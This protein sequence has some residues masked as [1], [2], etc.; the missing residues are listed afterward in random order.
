MGENTLRLEGQVVIV[1]G[2]ASGIGEAAARGFAAEG[3]KV[4]ITDVDETLGSSV[5]ASIPS[6]HFLRADVSQ[7]ADVAAAVD[8]ALSTYGRLDI[9]HNNAAIAGPLGPVT[10]LDMDAFDRVYSINLRGQVL[11]IKHAARAMIPAHRGTIICTS[12][13]ATILG[14]SAPNAYTFVK[15]AIPGIVRSA[16]AELGPHGIR[17]NAISPLGVPTPGMLG[18]LKTL[19]AGNLTFEDMQRMLDEGSEFKGKPLR[20]EHI[21][22]AA[23]FLASDAGGYISGQNL[24]IDGGFS[25]TKTYNPFMSLLK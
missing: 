23:V 14:G 17:V 2:A 5:A 9:M 22:Q 8:F 20:A 13:V 11:G 6:A 4:I 19:G 12:S 18:G 1:T 24:V 10:L 3:A 15:S 21:A 25:V 16:A 7:E